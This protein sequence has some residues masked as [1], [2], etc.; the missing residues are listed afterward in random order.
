[1]KQKL[2]YE[3]LKAANQEFATITRQYP[4]YL[5]IHPHGEDVLRE[6][7]IDYFDDPDSN[8]L[9]TAKTMYDGELDPEYFYYSN[10][11]TS[12]TI[13][14][15]YFD[16]KHSYRF[17]MVERPSIK[18]FRLFELIGSDFPEI[19][20]KI[21][22]K[23]KMKL[24]E[25]PIDHPNIITWVKC[26]YEKNNNSNTYLFIPHLGIAEYLVINDPGFT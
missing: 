18:D 1:M 16:S 13:P 22:C 23:I 25:I 12:P 11:P 2:N 15:E 9:Y 20:E 6:I 19:K 8:F 4:L 14:I 17:Y 26:K 10:T 3:N 7:S 24:L 5:I 21:N